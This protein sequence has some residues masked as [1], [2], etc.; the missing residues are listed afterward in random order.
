[1]KYGIIFW[2]RDRESVKAFH[3]QKKVIQLISGIN[4]HDSCGLVFMDYRILAVALLYILEVLCF[5]KKFKVN[6][7][8]NFYVHGYNTRGRIDLH[9]KRL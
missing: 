7:K 8:R 9:T 5:I 4:T 3:I 1:M 6:L 2:G